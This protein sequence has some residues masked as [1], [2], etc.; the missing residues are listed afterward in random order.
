MAGFETFTWNA[1]D[2]GDTEVTVDLVPLDLNA[3]V[4]LV[5]EPDVP[6][7]REYVLVTAINGTQFTLSR[8]LEGSAEGVGAGGGSH[9]NPVKIR[10]IFTHQN[11]NDIWDAIVPPNG[12]EQ[13][14]LNHITDGGD[15]HEQ[16]GYLTEVDSNL[17]YVQLDGGNR[18]AMTGYLKLFADPVQATDAATKDYVD[19]EVGDQDHD[20]AT[21]IAAHNADAGAHT[22]LSTYLK[23]TGGT[24]SGNMTFDDQVIMSTAAPLYLQYAEANPVAGEPNVYISGTGK[25]HR[26]T[27]GTAYLPLAGGEMAGDITLS[28]DDTHSIGTESAELFK[29]F[30]HRLYSTILRETDG[31]NVFLFDPGLRNFYGPDGAIAI[32]INETPTL[33]VQFDRSIWIGGSVLSTNGDITAQGSVLALDDVQASR[34]LSVPNMPLDAGKSPN[35]YIDGTGKFWRTS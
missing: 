7:K 35:I 6:T 20:H 23:L 13:S 34:N 9:P 17:L 5:L 18:L 8:G 26:T 31:T 33:H 24:I 10:A 16:A 21:P 19:T 27:G 22:N 2:P 15:P 11:L 3:P 25:I 32:R 4:Y 28:A 1:Y 30:S 14:L 29:L 12:I